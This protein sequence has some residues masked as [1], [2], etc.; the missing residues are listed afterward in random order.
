MYFFK[1]KNSFP[2]SNVTYNTRHAHDPL[3]Q[4]HRLTST[5]HSVSYSATKVW[6]SL[7]PK[8]KEISS[9]NK[10]KITLKM[11]IINKYAN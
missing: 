6:N 9:M 8:I 10:F 1:N 11:V 3:I 7:P 5:E 4:S 2:I